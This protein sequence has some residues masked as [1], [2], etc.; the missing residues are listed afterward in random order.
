MKKLT[1]I[2][3]LFSLP[4]LLINL[5]ASTDDLG[6]AANDQLQQIQSTQPKTLPVDVHNAEPAPVEP[7]HI[8]AH[9]NVVPP[10]QPVP[11]Q[12]TNPVPGENISQHPD[13]ITA[14]LPPGTQKT[15]IVYVYADKPP[16]G[17]E[18]KTE[19]VDTDEYS[20]ELNDNP[21]LCFG[22]GMTN[23]VTCWL[24]IPRCIVY[25]NELLPVIGTVLGIPEGI[26]YTLVRALV[27]TAD[28]VS[29]GM[30]GDELYGKYLP[31]FVWE[32]NWVPPESKDKK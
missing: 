23:L 18:Q 20:S 15:K 14:E 2:I 19:K 10:P 25:D 16:V 27:G 17:T 9:E 21:L 6:T 4:L 5:S 11:V 26:G 12:N 31:D 24:E 28:I 3:G 8:P 29:F 32:A 22:R 30:A 7:Q 1:M 13:N